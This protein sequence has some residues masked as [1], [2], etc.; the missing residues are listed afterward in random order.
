MSELQETLAWTDIPLPEELHNLHP[1]QQEIMAS[2]V[3]NVVNRKTDGFEEL[4]QAIG[5][6]VK[7]IPHFVVIPL[8][9]E[10]IKPPIAAGVCRKMGVDQATGYANDL[11]LEYFS[12]V[13]RHIDAVMM[14]ELLGKMKRHHAEKFIHYELQHHLTHILD[15]AEHLEKRMLEVVAKHVT[16]PEHDDDFLKHPHH[17]IIEKIRA[18]Q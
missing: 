7:Y 16:L 2:Y 10:H 18:L 5:M 12:E 1:L 6:I 3:R 15:I 13:S 9:V 17:D 4:Y 11:P 8:M 14:S